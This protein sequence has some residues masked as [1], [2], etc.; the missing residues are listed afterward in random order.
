MD[1]IKRGEQIGSQYHRRQDTVKGSEPL[2]WAADAQQHSRV[3]VDEGWGWG[4]GGALTF[5]SKVFR[6]TR[7]PPGTGGF[8]RRVSL[9]T[10][11]V[12]LSCSKVSMSNLL[13]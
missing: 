8:N 7:N 4:T 10:H 13:S 9:M 6:A 11:P 3:D 1:G 2:L 5:S 12:Y